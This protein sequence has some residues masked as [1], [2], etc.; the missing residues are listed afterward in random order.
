MVVSLMVVYTCVRFNPIQFNIQF[1]SVQFGSVL[2]LVITN[3]FLAS[4]NLGLADG[5]VEITTLCGGF[6]VIK[7]VVQ[8]L[9]FCNF[10]EDNNFSPIWTDLKCMRHMLLIEA[11]QSACNRLLSIYQSLLLSFST[12]PTISK[13]AHK[14]RAI[15]FIFNHLKS[16]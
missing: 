9:F 11:S 12:I 3:A 5:A 14:L 15:I 10:N 7:I 2:S 16:T 13:W 4:F 6:P 8:I 1:R